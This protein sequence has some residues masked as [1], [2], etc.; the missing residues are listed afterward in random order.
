MSGDQRFEELRG[1]VADVSRE[2]FADLAA[3]ESL[4]RKWAPSINLAAPSTIAS[5]WTRHIVDCAQLVALKPNARRWLDLGSGGGFPGLVIAILQKGRDGARVDLVE[6]AGKKAAFLRLAAG[7]LG[8]PAKVHQC[9]I[10]AA[11]SQIATPEIVTARALAA[12]PKLFELSEP[13]LADGATGLFQKGRDYRREVEASR[14]AWTFDLVEHPSV[15]E[16]DAAIL[17]IA[18]LKRQV[19]G[20][21][22]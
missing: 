2:T 3:F 17:E 12:L 16:P 13:W 11:A 7:T 5:L 18:G 4:F 8:I 1:V 15:T 21:S 10:E 22:T 19:A 14:Y 6:S 9:R 20:R